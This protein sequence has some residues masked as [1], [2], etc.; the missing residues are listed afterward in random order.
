MEGEIV[1]HYRVGAKLG[2]G[3]MGVVYEA[4]DL[5]LGRK[6]ALKFLYSGVKGDD[7]HAMDRLQ[8]EA[9]TA[10]KLNH[11]NICTI[12]AIEEHR[13]RPVLVMEL[14]EGED[15]RQRVRAAPVTVQ[16]LIRTGVQACE[17]LGAAHARG[18]VHRDIKPANIFATNDGRLKLLDFGVAKWMQATEPDGRFGKVAGTILYMSPEQLRGEEI[19]GRSDLFS[20]GVVLY[21]LATGIRPFERSDALLTM[22]AVLHDTVAAPSNVNRAL[23]SSFDRVIGTDARERSRTAISLGSRRFQG[24]D[25]P[26]PATVGSAK[27]VEAGGRRCRAVGALRYG[28]NLFRQTSRARIN[29]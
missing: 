3:G 15:L 8:A 4:E 20:L 19:D 12:Y 1:L 2:N 22:E 18:I 24:T 16:E 11:P 9:R 17:A 14:L 5:K 23:P 6:V 10:S 29:G 7:G 27:E 25:A 13:G 28:R 26:R 21:E